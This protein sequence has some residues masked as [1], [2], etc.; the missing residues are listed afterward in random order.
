MNTH[1]ALDSD[2]AS[3]GWRLRENTS[4]WSDTPQG[5]H[6]PRDLRSH[7]LEPADDT[8]RTHEVLG[9][10]SRPQL[11][12]SWARHTKEVQEAQRLRHRVYIEGMGA[13][14]MPSDA[15]PLGVDSD[16]FDAHCHHLIVRDFEDT[17][18]EHGRV[19]GTCRVMTPDAALRAGGLC[20]DDHFDLDAL[21][22]MRPA[23]VELGRPCV[24]PSHRQGVVIML[25]WNRL[26]PF[27]RENHWRWMLTSASV[28]TRDGG[29][30]A[31]SLWRA[32]MIEH[33]APVAQRVKPRS[34]LPL[35]QLRQCD[36]VATTPM[37]SSFLR[38]GAVLLGAPAL[39]MNSAALPML[40]TLNARGS[41]VHHAH[42]EM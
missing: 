26:V 5:R 20:S 6:R 18:D 23:M 42:A 40:I 36:L 30:H 31:A 4:L 32:L 17:G 3:L 8:R 15:T 14:H 28:P 24:D 41:T 33:A 37:I 27:M 16:R 10:A 7:D 19:V 12:A 2:A 9:M 21:D 39:V 29:H 1:P 38:C 35:H 11:T 13:H 22:A 25:L 34:A